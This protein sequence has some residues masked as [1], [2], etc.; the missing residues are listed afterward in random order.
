[1]ARLYED[2]ANTQ[3][4]VGIVQ[5]RTGQFDL[6]AAAL[7]N[8][9]GLEPSLPSTKFLLALARFGQRRYNDA[10]VLLQQVPASDPMYGPAQ[11]RLRDIDAT[12]P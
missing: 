6:A 3:R 5:L 10:R 9:L 11:E 1:M 12:V 4:A 7:S 2:D 8:S